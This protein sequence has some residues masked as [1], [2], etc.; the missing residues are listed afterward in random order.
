[1]TDKHMIEGTPER[2]AD[3]GRDMFDAIVG[4]GALASLDGVEGMVRDF[5]GEIVDTRTAYHNDEIDGP[6]ASERVQAIA[7]KYADIFMGKDQSY[8]PMP[9]NS[10]EQLGTALAANIEDSTP[11]N[12]AEHFLLRSAADFMATVLIPTEND[13]IDDEI[14]EFRT[15]AAV[16]DL[17]YAMLGLRQDEPED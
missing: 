8:G 13:E 2:A 4:E 6:A 7:K 11:E 5:F 3:R 16:E 14:G 10:P 9:W 15:N 17:T 1:M 12:A